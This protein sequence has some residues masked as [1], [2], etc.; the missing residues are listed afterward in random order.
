[1][2]QL[3]RKVILTG[4]LGAVMAVFGPAGAQ[5]STAT[6]PQPSPSGPATPQAAAPTTSPRTPADDATPREPSLL[7]V[8]GQNVSGV[9]TLGGVLAGLLAGTWNTRRTI[10]AAAR[11]SQATIWQKANEAELQAIQGKLESFYGPFTQL[12]GINRLL[13]GDLR[14]RLGR[15]AD[16]RLLTALF[17]PGWLEALSPGDAQ[18]VRQICENAG[19]LERLVEERAG[20]VDEALA[21]YLARVATHFRMLQLAGERRLG[22]DPK[23]FERYVYP[24]QLD[25]VIRLEVGRLRRRSE[26]L[27]AMPAAPAGPI[28]P[29]EVPRAWHSTLGRAFRPVRTVA[30][31]GNES[32]RAPSRRVGGTSPP[33]SMTSGS[34]R[35][36]RGRRRARRPIPRRTRP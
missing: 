21:P 16:F 3:R 34:P 5:T 36:R 17:E 28:G 9:L 11:A 31:G 15:G 10:Q 6:A 2:D 4:A 19:R 33:H 23:P 29:L 8:L 12:S 27:R 7:Q 14:G 32:R 1:M 26:A 13:A 35:G 22:D 25:D 24:R 18:V 30:R 20:A